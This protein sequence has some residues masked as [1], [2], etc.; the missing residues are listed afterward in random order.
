M[1]NVNFTIEQVTLKLKNGELLCQEKSGKSEVWLN[2]DEIIK[3]IRS[4]PLGLYHIN[5]NNLKDY[6]GYYVFAI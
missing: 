4:L 6:Y 5:V 2:F 1:A 3:F